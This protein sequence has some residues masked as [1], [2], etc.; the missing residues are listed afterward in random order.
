MSRNKTAATAQ[1]EKIV[2]VVMTKGPLSSFQC[3]SSD[4]ISAAVIPISSN[5]A[6]DLRFSYILQ[7]IAKANGG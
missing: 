4:A 6:I 7:L 1:A 3:K 2:R 5:L